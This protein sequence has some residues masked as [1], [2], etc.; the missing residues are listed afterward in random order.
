LPQRRF[1]RLTAVLTSAAVFLFEMLT[2]V[3]A[4][5]THK[6]LKIIG[7]Y[8][9]TDVTPKHFAY[10]HIHTCVNQYLKHAHICNN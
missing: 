6:T 9:L 3:T 8:V 5:V 2:D 4:S 10:T 7:C 1:I